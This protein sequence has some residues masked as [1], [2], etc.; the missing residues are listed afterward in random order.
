MNY[1]SE[2]LWKSVEMIVKK[3]KTINFKATY[4]SIRNVFSF[5]CV[6]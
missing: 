2:K 6:K 5:V 1:E 4:N 3:Y